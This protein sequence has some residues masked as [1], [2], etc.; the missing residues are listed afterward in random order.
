[1]VRFDIKRLDVSVV[2]NRERMNSKFIM[3]TASGWFH[4][5]NAIDL[6]VNIA[7]GVIRVIV[8]T[9][10]NCMSSQEMAILAGIP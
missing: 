3:S 1:M 9:G 7:S 5:D 8:R 10:A 2:Q 4:R 6:L